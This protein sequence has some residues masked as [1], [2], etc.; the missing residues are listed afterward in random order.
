M[1]VEI[2]Y[3]INGVIQGAMWSMFIFAFLASVMATIWWFIPR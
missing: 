3:A 1:D 2:I